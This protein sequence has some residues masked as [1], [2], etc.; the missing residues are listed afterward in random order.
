MRRSLHLLLSNP[1]VYRAAQ[2]LLAPGADYYF[3]K[4]VSVL[5]NISDER[6]WLDVGCGPDSR[7]PIPAGGLIALDVSERY[8][9]A[10]NREGCTGCVGGATQLPFPANHFGAVWTVGLLHHLSDTDVV[11]ALTEMVR[12][13]DKSGQ[14]FVFDAVL[15]E[16]RWRRLPAY[17][18]RRADRGRFMRTQ[19]E[20]ERLLP[21][22]SVWRVERHT[23]THNG[24]EMLACVGELGTA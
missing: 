2:K 8:I 3:R 21:K 12:V 6:S 4:L 20:L 24:L 16:P 19:S 18:I 7:V 9:S 17:L 13:C 15:P 5:A 11:S 10:A 14:I 23:Y 1:R 22:S